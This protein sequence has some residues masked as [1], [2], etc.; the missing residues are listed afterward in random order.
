MPEKIKELARTYMGDY[1][2]ICIKK[3]QLTTALTEQIYFEVKASDKF[4][5]LCRLIDIEND[6]YGLVFCRTKIDTDELV[7]HLIDRGYDA[8]ALHGDITQSQRERALDKFK[9]KRINVLVAT[10]VAARGIDVNNLTHVINYS[11][12]H[13]PEAYI[14]RIGRTGRAGNEGTAITF[15]TPSEYSKLM[16]IQ[17]FTK[18]SIKKARV[19]EV[20]DIIKAKKNKVIN[21]LSKLLKNGIEPDFRTMAT[22]LLEGRNPTDTVAALLNYCFEDDFRPDNYNEIKDFGERGKELDQQG[23]TRLFVGLGKK[24]K[25]TPQKLSGLIISRVPIHFK[26][27]RDIQIMENFSFVTVPF[28]DAERIL[29]SFREKGKKALIS[30]ARKER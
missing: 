16:F 13:D 18:T 9:K 7:T 24:D 4:E 20:T 17:R 19:P 15:I 2:L 29:H 11:L 28:E 14:H 21:D 10:D 26:H 3:E 8:E 6:F 30:P 25:M 5:A 27:I 1:R 12:P 22:R 23:K